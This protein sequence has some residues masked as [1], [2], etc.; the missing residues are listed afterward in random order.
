MFHNLRVDV[1]VGPDAVFSERFAQVVKQKLEKLSYLKWR[2]LYGPGYLLVSI[3]N[4]FFGVRVKRLLGEM[5][6]TLQI[7]NQGCF[8]SIYISYRIYEGYRVER[9][10]PH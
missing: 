2:D 3:Q 4:P 6:P 9:W 10:Q 1:L 5:W 8:R 7:D